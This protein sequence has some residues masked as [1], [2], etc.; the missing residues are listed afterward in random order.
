MAKKLPSAVALATALLWTAP[1][2]AQDATSVLAAASRAMGVETLKTIEYSA[3]GFDFA[4]GQSGMPG[5]AWPRFINKSYTRQVNF[6]TPASKLD[7]VRAQ[8]ENPP[9]GGGNQPLQGDQNQSQTIIVAQNTP[10]AQQLEL[11]MLPHGFL[12]AAATRNP[13]VQKMGN[14]NV[15]SFQGGNGAQ[16]RGYI[17]AQ[18]LVERVATMIDHPVTGDTPLE[19]VFL[20]YRAV[21][22]VQWPHKII[23]RQ[24]G[25]PI[26]DLDIAQVRVNAPVDIQAAAQGGGGGGGGGGQQQG[27]P[28]VELAPGVLLFNSGYAVMAFDMGDHLLFL[29][30]GNSQQRAQQVIAEAKRRFPNKP[31]RYVVNTH[32]HFDHSSGLRA[33]VAEGATILTHQMNRAY[34]EEL[35]RRPHTLSPD[36]QEQANQPV[37]VQGVPDRHVITGN[38]HTIEL[39]RMT[40]FGHTPAMLMA[41]LPQ[42][43]ILY[44]A[45]GY[46]A[47]AADAQPPATPSPYHLALLANVQRLNLQVDRVIPTHYPADDRVITLAEIRR[48]ARQSTN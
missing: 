33:F 7:R 4:F 25:Y 22:G 38:G 17:N 11:Y 31:V 30:P 35:M 20:D 41:Y 39:H 3:T 14:V 8:G 26:F 10:W 27:V 43:R 9:F 34:V 46:N 24:G 12:R 19:A 32:P 15:V 28:V 16:V 2:Q 44:E 23:Q 29:E 5:G 40:N 47:G 37:R 48:M 13:T 6:E 1:V 45:D 18:G 42:H 36:A 21:D